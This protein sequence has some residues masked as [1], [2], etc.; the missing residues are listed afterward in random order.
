[1]FTTSSRVLTLLALLGALPLSPAA[2]QEEAHIAE[3]VDFSKPPAKVEGYNKVRFTVS[4]EQTPKGLILHVSGQAYYPDG[5]RLSILTRYWK[6]TKYLNRK[7]PVVKDRAFSVDIGPLPKSIPGGELTV[8][9][10]FVLSKQAA[11]VKKAFMDG[12]YN[13]CTPPCRFD[14]LNVTRT[15]HVMRGPEG[16][17]QAESAEKGKLD[18]ALR[19]VLAARRVAEMTINDVRKEKTSSE[20]AKKAMEQLD[21]DLKAAVEPLNSW[22]Q[23][24]LFVLFPGHHSN[25]RGL[26]HSALVEVQ[27]HAAVAGVKLVVEG[28][29]RVKTASG[30]VDPF[31]RYGRAKVEIETKIE[32]LKGFLAES[33]SLDRLWKEAGELAIARDKAAKE[34]AEKIKKR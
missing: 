6:S 4:G 29:P 19:A 26:V 11:R 3:T 28:G 10:W 30:R 9:G 27:L 34:Q 5:I 7:T 32:D 13:S 12:K 16:Q 22:T 18:E 17:A 25:L 20:I 33:G 2:A 1:L 15:P 31:T 8:E 21:T 24:Q 14:R 23:E